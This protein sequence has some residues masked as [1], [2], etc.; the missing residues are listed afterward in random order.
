MRTKAKI[1]LLEWRKFVCGAMIIILPASL[2]AQAT[3]RAVLHSDGGTLLDESTAMGTSAIFRDA[4]IQTLPAHV[5]TIDAEGS[6]A[7]VLPETLVQ[8]EDNELVLDHGELQVTTARAL[9]VRVGCLTIVPTT[10]DRTQY[11]VLDR[12]GKV[13]VTA[14][15]NNV[16]IQSRVGGNHPKSLESSDAIVREGHQSARDEK[17]GA[18]DLPT[19]PPG[20][21]PTLDGLPARIAAAAIIITVTCYALCH[22]D[23][24]IS[25]SVP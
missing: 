1:Y 3:D 24:P 11:D 23:D 8:F 9:R 19:R 16:K 2:I 6:S 13:T 15:K 21:D 4:L 22:S 18:A 7:T 5:A 12:N 25:P 17:C 20:A 14:F 10:L